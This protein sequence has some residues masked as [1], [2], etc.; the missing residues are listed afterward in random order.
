MGGLPYATCFP[1]GSPYTLTVNIE[2]D[3]GLIN[4]AIGI[5]RYKK[6]TDNINDVS[7]DDDDDD[8][9]ELQDCLEYKM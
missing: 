7:D 5:V 2:V 6:Y 3:D 1:I 8:D 4:G 9:D